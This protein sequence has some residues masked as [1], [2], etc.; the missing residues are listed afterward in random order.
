ME[1]TERPG[2]SVYTVSAF[3]G[4]YFLYGNFSGRCQGSG[5]NPWSDVLG[6]GTRAPFTWTFNSANNTLNQP[7]EEKTNVYPNPFIKGK[8]T[9]KTITFAD[10]PQAATLR[11]YTLSGDLIKILKHKAVARGGK[12]D[13][14]IS[15]AG[16]GVYLYVISSSEGVEKGKISVMK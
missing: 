6:N 7:P 10:L 5:I 9:E 4:E 15:N 13:W 16:S 3:F 8:N 14:D 11:I 2:I 12:E 1:W